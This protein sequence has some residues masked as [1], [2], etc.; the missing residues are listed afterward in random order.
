[1]SKYKKL[2]L[3]FTI[4]TLIVFVDTGCSKYSSMK[5]DE[6]HRRKQFKK[7][8]KKKQAEIDNA[9]KA[10]VQRQY[11]I[12]SPET[13]KMMQENAK[14]SKEYYDKTHHKKEFFLTRWF[15]KI[16]KPGRKKAPSKQTQK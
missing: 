2:F 15:K 4:L 13:Q 3:I 10:S 5:R 9:H 12:Q 8:E 7:D 11:D 1:M 14:K 16:F 6:K